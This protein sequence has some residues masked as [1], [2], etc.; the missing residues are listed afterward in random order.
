M[1]PGPEGMTPNTCTVQTISS[2]GENLT[3][4]AERA[5]SPAYSPDG[6]RI[7][8]LSDRDEHGTHLTGSDEVDFA[9]ELYVM[10]GDGGNPER[11]TETEGSTRRARPGLPTASGSPMRARGPR[12]S[13]GS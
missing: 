2:T 10:D 5:S 8:F 3:E 6:K 9:N 1:P 7:A 13:S 11:L 12:I 4:L